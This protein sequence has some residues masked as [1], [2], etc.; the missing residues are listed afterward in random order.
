[1]V[2]GGGI[3]SMWVVAPSLRVHI[4]RWFTERTSGVAPRELAA[5]VHGADIQVEIPFHEAWFSPWPMIYLLI[6]YM[7]IDPAIVLLIVLQ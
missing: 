4:E 2:S 7:L 1:M 3:S 6:K 5:A